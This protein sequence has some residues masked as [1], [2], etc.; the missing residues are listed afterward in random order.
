MQLEMVPLT[1]GAHRENELEQHYG[2]EN[3]TEL[4]IE[5][6]HRNQTVVEWKIYILEG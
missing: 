1:E 5:A 4:R 2:P 6:Q 3:Q